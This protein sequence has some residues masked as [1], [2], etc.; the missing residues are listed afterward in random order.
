MKLTNKLK[1]L[2]KKKITL[3]LVITLGFILFKSYA[4]HKNHL[5]DK[6]SFNPNATIK[7]AETAVCEREFMVI[8]FE[9][10]LGTAPY[11]FTYTVNNGA[12]QTI[13]SNNLGIAEFN[14]REVF[15][16]NFTYKLTS[17]RDASSEIIPIANQEVS[18][19]VNALPQNEVGE[20]AFF[21][22]KNFVCAGE[23][24]TFTP[25]VID[26]GGFKYL[27]TF[28]DGVTSELES[29]SHSVEAFGCTTEDRVFRVTLE[30]TN[31]NGCKNS[32]VRIV[33]VTPK[34]D[35]EFFD[36]DFG[37]FNNCDN[38]SIA[39]PQ[40]TV[41][42]G[43]K[44]KSDCVDSY[45][46]D[47]GDGNTETSITT[48]PIAHTYLN[49]GIYD[50]KVKGN[51]EN[52]CFSELS[53]QVINISHPVGDFASLE[54]TD[55]VCLTDA[56]IDFEIT[57]FEA[58]WEDTTYTVD[59]GDGSPTETYTHTEIQNNNKLSHTYD[60]GSCTLPNGEYVAT[61]S[62]EN[63]CSIT[64]KTI[65]NITILE[66]SIA[67]FESPEI[68]C[69]N[70]DVAF[71]N[72]STIG[73]NDDCNK[74]ANFTWDFGDGTPIISDNGSGVLTNKTHQY[75][76]SGTFTV[77]LSVTT[78][79]NTAVFT[80]DICIEEVNTPTFTVDN[81]A[82]C[83]PLNVAATN[84]T[85]ENTVCS[86]ASYE[87]EVTY[88]AGNCETTGSWSFANGTDKNSE[89]PQFLF[90]NPGFYTLIQKIITG[91]GTE[92]NSKIIEVKKPPIVSLNPIDD[93]CDHLTI[94]PIATIENC[95]SNI[96]NVTYNWT[97][98]GGNPSSAN[99]LDP[100]NIVYNTPGTYEITL[101]I[102]NECGVS[103]V[104]T[105]TFEVFEKSII[106]N[107]DLTQEICSNESTT[108][109]NLTSTIANTTYTWTAAASPGISSFITSGD[110]N[111]IPSQT[112]INSQNGSGTVTY[113]VI[114][115]VNGCDGNAVD[116]IIT[117]NST[118]RFTTQP[119]SSEVCQNTPA[120]LLEVAFENGTG[121][122][123]YQ[124]FSNTTDSNSDGTAI[125]DE[126]GSSYNP[127]TD[128]IGELFYYVEISFSG[129]VCPKIVSNTASV[130][131]IQQLSI[132]TIN[133]FQTYCIGGSTNELEVSYSGTENVT[134]QWFSNT[135]NNTSG[136]IINGETRST[137]TPPTFS[138]TGSFYYYAKVSLNITG[139]S[140][141]ASEVFEIN[142]VS[143]PIID[144]QP[145]A[146]LA[147]C[148]GA[149]PVDLFVTV[150]GGTSS[151][152]NYQWYQNSGGTITMVGNNSNSYTPNTNNVGTLS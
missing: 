126:T 146:S 95:T 11:F 69:T 140:T 148:K 22:D 103:N 49:L 128:A 133:A 63:L 4:S 23:V 116:F 58:N 83:I 119:L 61:L 88:A 73:E 36:A 78:Q 138:T 149:T 15:A 3:F 65:N 101:Q 104:A 98:V 57:N 24:I 120:T 18:I 25:N 84:T 32:W 51:G 90:S 139:C 16:G 6:L 41:N 20:E 121:T 137:F 127:P 135:A 64:E 123:T 85:T 40:F 93:A 42:V 110:T 72:K 13:T 94:N 87:W 131:V 59:F 75:T 50:M 130:I 9:G 31:T 71:V 108:E 34:P 33:T 91:C 70:S 100:G 145:I 48:F 151:P 38:A 136:N 129:S 28:E 86:A 81:D 109:I 19:L 35:L 122:A 141:V 8:T 5:I 53:Y 37:D 12:E 46:I 67:E 105:Q 99:T 62:M 66:P 82:G 114:P 152:K 76:S 111:T 150:S 21:F 29:P 45:D 2:L 142:V 115:S 117:V 68:A 54:N 134:Y 106:T 144:T 39:T 74:A 43:N 96:G 7:A 47:W 55:N 80:K 92:T 56:K 132:T 26:T 1:T 112:I 17:V 77:T 10:S 124:W 27:W 107:T 79:C 125:A 89:N 143:D 52:G 118:P 97:F 102:T 147:F 30:V 113:T 14:F 60:K 44:S